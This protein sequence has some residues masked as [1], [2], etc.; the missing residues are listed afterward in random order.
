MNQLLTN[1]VGLCDAM[2]D[3]LTRKQQLPALILIYAGIDIVASVEA[4]ANE[5]TRQSFTR[6]VD[7]YLLSSQ[8]LRCTSLDLFAARCAMVHTLSAESDLSRCGKA[9]AIFY[10]WGNR[11]AEE[12]NDALAHAG[13]SDQAVGVHIGQLRE[14]FLVGVDKWA[15]DVRQ[16]SERLKQ[17]EAQG[18]KWFVNINPNVH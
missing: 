9:R 15:T 12:L 10:A 13:K 2:G 3:C 8:I 4:R 6:W 17:V 18:R 14:A 5:G 1:L 11:E 16:D 7:S